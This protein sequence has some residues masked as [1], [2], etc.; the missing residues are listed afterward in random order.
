MNYCQLSRTKITALF[1]RRVGFYEIASRCRERC[2]AAHRLFLHRRI[3]ASRGAFQKSIYDSDE[4]NHRKRTSV[5]SYLHCLSAI[6]KASKLL[7]SFTSLYLVFLGLCRLYDPSQA[8][9]T[10]SD[11]SERKPAEARRLSFET[12]GNA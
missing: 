8:A 10:K 6:W 11:L 1:P 9:P 7:K 4:L 12:H 2:A 3:R 5:N